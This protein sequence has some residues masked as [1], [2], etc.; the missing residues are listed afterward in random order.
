VTQPSVLDLVDDENLLG[1]HFRGPSWD[2]WRAV[3]RAAFAL[4]MS[5]A[6]L[7]SFAAVSGDRPPPR[8]RVRELIVI[9][10]RRSGKDSIASALA[11]AAAVV[12]YSDQLRPGER[13]SILC[14]AV[15]REQARIVNRYIRG[16][17]NR[18]PLL[19]PL[20]EHETDD[21]LELT[22]DVEVIVATNSY[23]AVR[24]R[25]IACAIFDE[26]SFW[27]SEESANPDVETY[28][29]VLPGMVTLPDAM[30]V[31][32]TTAY[33]RAGLAYT[34]W[35]KH[36]G[37]DDDDVLVVYGPSTAFNP[38]LPQ[39]VIDAALAADPEAAGA[40]W[41]SQWRSDLSDFLD[42]ELIAAA[43]DPGVVVRP[44]DPTTSYVAFADPSGGRGDAF[45]MAIGHTDGNQTILDCLYEKRS[46]F[47][48]SAAVAEIATLLRSYSLASVM[49][50][51]YAANW[52]TEGFAR[53][54][55]SYRQADRD[56]SAIYLDALPLF[57]AGR[58]RILDHA[59]LIH[60]LA[61]LERR[62]SRIGKDRV[63]HPPGGAD[64]LANSAAGAL[65]LAADATTPALWR[66]ADLLSADRPISW[67]TLC[68][69]IFA[70]A[71]VD[72][73]GVFI[74]FWASGGEL[75]GA[76]WRCLLIDYHRTTI[77]PDLSLATCLRI[78]E[79]ARQAAGA[80]PGFIMCTAPLIP[81]L[82]H[83][84]PIAQRQA[85]RMLQPIAREATIL[86]VL[87]Q[88]G[89]NAVKITEIADATSRSLPLPFTAVGVAMAQSAAQDVVLLG[90]GATL[91][92]EAKP[93]EWSQ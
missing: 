81:H 84:P 26:A 23:R 59:R 63:D 93:K 77:T 89:S 17:F 75:F 19:T 58:A 87:A 64:D 47:D 15:N 91:P 49:G 35:Q 82:R 20:V 67:P 34:M 53:E 40:E 66:P 3:M 30:L 36:F 8:R 5:D 38:L 28:N 83:S 18:I 31:V 46:P 39:Y 29:A 61:S 78:D 80:A 9:A 37:K 52:V 65:V 70:T 57:T 10:G 25:T 13:A 79:L 51:R 86:A 2:T 44:P 88:I 16:Y 48:P 22:N 76:D 7:Q 14:L 42:R 6:D 45:T 73:A 71:S 68:R 85:A 74:A 1:P 60:Q 21:G 69:V 27:R 12:D 62:T 92:P 4:P 33:R 43:T 50:D 54:G 55:I 41:L 72:Q 24:G 32:I 11:T 56:R 90:V